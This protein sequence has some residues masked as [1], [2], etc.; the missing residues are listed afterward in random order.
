MGAVGAS[1]PTV[2]ESVGASTHGFWQ[3]SHISINFHRIDTENVTKVVISCPKIILSTHSLKFL[4]GALH[5]I[6]K[7]YH[8]P[9]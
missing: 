8:E 5:P 6:A 1:G 3:I 9:S 2:F 7:K 4:T